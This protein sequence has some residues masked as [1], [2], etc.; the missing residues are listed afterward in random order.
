MWTA[1][2]LFLKA[3]W[4]ALAE[5]AALVGSIIGA[6]YAVYR[7]GGKAKEND[8]I[9]KELGYAKE[10]LKQDATVAGNTDVDGM[11]IR[12][13]EALRRKRNS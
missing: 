13:S 2:K 7:A 9:K 12:L 10:A 3:N 4:L 6:I 8:T 1:I 5:K 11:R